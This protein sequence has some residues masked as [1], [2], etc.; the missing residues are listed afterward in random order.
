[1]KDYFFFT[2][3]SNVSNFFSY[4]IP[5]FQQRGTERSELLLH[6]SPKS[7]FHFSERWLQL[8]Y[9]ASSVQL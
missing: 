3:I 7:P 6:P 8:R 4:R 5:S 9:C 1:M 2:N